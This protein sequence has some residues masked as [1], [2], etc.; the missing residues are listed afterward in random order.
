LWSFSFPD[1]EARRVCH[2]TRNVNQ[3][4]ETL[5][6][7]RKSNIIGRIRPIVHPPFYIPQLPSTC[8]EDNYSARVAHFATLK[9][10]FP[11]RGH[12]P[13]SLYRST[14][15]L[16]TPWPFRHGYGSD[17]NP[18]RLQKQAQIPTQ[19]HPAKRPKMQAQQ[20]RHQPRTRYRRT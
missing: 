16:D 9:P 18:P 8:F 13:P 2:V 11:E 19:P 6:F 4:Q 15:H 1:L 12:H 7:S 3:V 20:Q 14:I 10:S 5:T 17:I